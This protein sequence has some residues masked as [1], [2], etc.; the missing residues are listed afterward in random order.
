[1]DSKVLQQFVKALRESGLSPERQNHW[2]S[3]MA[4]QNFSHADERAFMQ[5]LADKIVDLNDAIAR[6]E[7]QL[8]LQKAEVEQAEVD[9][10]PDLTAFADEQPALLEEELK[11]YKRE[12]YKAEQEMVDALK[13]VRASANVE[14]IEALRKKLA[15]G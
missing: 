5:E 8:A 9:V 7:A 13:T 1:M 2:I 15:G 3:K 12:V 14:D 10:I 4:S 11:S 6:Q